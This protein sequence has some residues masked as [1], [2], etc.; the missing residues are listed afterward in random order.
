MIAAAYVALELAVSGRYGFQQDELY[1]LVASHH[2]ALGYVDQP[3]LA[4]LL[5]RTTDVLGV[6]PMAVR[7]LP[8]LAGGIVILL[9]GRLAA[10]FGGRGTA[11]VIAA[12]AVAIAP[13]FLG[14]MHIGN[15]T[16]YDLLAWAAVSVCVATALLR[17]RPRWWVGAGVA[18]GIGLNDEYLILTLLAALV[19]G[20]LL[21]AAHRHVLATRWPWIGGG[22][23]LALWLP[24]LSWQFANGWPQLAMASALHA[25]NTSGS[26]YVSGLPGQFVYAGLLGTVLGI[27]GLVALWRSP[28]LRFLAVA[29]TL[30]LLYVLAWVPGKIYYTDG[31]LPVILA[32]GAVSAEGWIA[33]GRPR[34]RRLALGALATVGT[35]VLLPSVLPILPV[36]QLHRL[37]GAT[38]IADGV[39]WPELTDAVA[40]QDRSLARAGQPPTSIFTGAFAEAGALRLYGA[41]HHLPPVVS[42]H[43]AFWTWGPGDASNTTV[44]Y[45]AGAD[46]LR[47]YFA[48]CH[49]LSV[50]NP[51]HQVKNDWNNLPIGVCT[52]PTAPWKVLWPKLKHYD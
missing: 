19:L 36:T 52:G 34:A 50:Y 20:I 43:N 30:I 6:N 35:L 37:N 3:P 26:D 45:V 25:Q 48:H 42:G 49:R 29:A 23:A 17:E 12:L 28:R 2:P 16:P 51:P 22:I 13:I 40:A 46:Q 39:G 7:I 44:L 31:I 4:V 41:G 27:A 8:A 5:A 21:T 10:L 9:T 38:S 33:R 32:A 18:A 11:R 24:N 15:T 14:A 1:F 47:P